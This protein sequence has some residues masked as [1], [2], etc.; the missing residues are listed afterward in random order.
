MT[1][2]VIL[3]TDNQTPAFLRATVDGLDDVD[4]LLLILQY[5]VKLIVVSGAK[6]THHVLVAEE[7]HNGARVVEL[8]HSVEVRDLID[9][10]EVNGGEI[11]DLVGNFEEDLVLTHTVLDGDG[12]L[13]Q[14]VENEEF[15]D[16][17]YR[18][19]VATETDDDETLTLY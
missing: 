19:M 1:G 17:S 13:A 14:Y 15:L 18:I 16:E 10:A 8:V 11:L 6:V 12:V 2:A 3:R 7:E 4:E 5:P 9:I